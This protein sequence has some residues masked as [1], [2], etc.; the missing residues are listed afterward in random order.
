MDRT[1]AHP[2][3]G[4]HVLALS[5]SLSQLIFISSILPL[6]DVSVF[7]TWARN[8]LRRREKENH[9]LPINYPNLFS[10]LDFAPNKNYWRPSWDPMKGTFSGHFLKP[11]S[12]SI[13]VCWNKKNVRVENSS[14]SSDQVTLTYYW[15]FSRLHIRCILN[16][17]TLSWIVI[18]RSLCLFNLVEFNLLSKQLGIR[19]LAGKTSPLL[20]WKFWCVPVNLSTYT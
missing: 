20:I 16:W 12:R 2:L 6:Q 14:L 3:A 10:R 18:L 11:I 9:S 19:Y 15:L 1:Q 17:T 4:S 7:V 13:K 5:L 8:K